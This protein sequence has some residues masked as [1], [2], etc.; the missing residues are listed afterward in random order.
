MQTLPP[1]NIVNFELAAQIRTK[2]EG[3][4][5]IRHGNKENGNGEDILGD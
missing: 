2:E 3:N 4:R 1:G 5:R